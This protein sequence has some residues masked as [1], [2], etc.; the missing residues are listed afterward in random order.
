[1]DIDR[2]EAAAIRDELQRWHDEARSLISDASDKSRLS[3]SSIEHLKSRLVTLKAEIKEAAK[4]ET[5]SRRKAERTDLERC[6]FGPA[7][8]STSAN[9]HMRTDT[10][11]RSELWSRGLFEVEME[12]SYKL[13][14]IEKLLNDQS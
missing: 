5:L 2:H 12:L 6:Y 11:P 13:H 9:F 14:G 3:A 8:R 10:N 7:V 4:H 1:M